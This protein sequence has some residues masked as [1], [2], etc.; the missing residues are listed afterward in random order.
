MSSLSTKRLS[1]YF[2]LGAAVGILFLIL[3]RSEVFLYRCID[4]LL[5]ASIFPLIIGGFRFSKNAGSFELFIYALKKLPKRD[6]NKEQPG[7]Y[8]DYLAQEKPDTSYK[9]PL[10]A[11]GV[12]LIAAIIMIAAFY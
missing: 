4:G 10:L 8:S 9:E 12:Y 11:G 7:S 6:K 2:L 1:F 5:A 3:D